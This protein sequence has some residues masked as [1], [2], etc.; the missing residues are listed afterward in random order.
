LS[1]YGYEPTQRDQN[2]FI[3]EYNPLL[4]GALNFYP[5]PDI[6]ST[7]QASQTLKIR[8]TLPANYE[9]SGDFI[10]SPITGTIIHE[11]ILDIDLTNSIGNKNLT[12]RYYTG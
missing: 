8:S 3:A 11:T 4:A 10:A 2:K 5:D 9:L 7:T 6:V 12:I 1:T